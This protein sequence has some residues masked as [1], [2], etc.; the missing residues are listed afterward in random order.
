M[1]SLHLV[2][3]SWDDAARFVAMWHRHHGPPPGGKF[4][5]GAADD[6]GVLRGVHITGR[7]VAR[8]FDDGRTLEVTRLATDGTRNA[9]SLLYAAAWRA[10][11]ALGYTRLVTYTQE[12]ES[13][14]SLKAAGYQVVAQRAPRAGWT[15]PSRPRDDKG[16]DGIAR[17]LWEA[18]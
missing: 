5:A 7:P 16:A 9:G 15:C 18:M 4:W 6:M 13:G 11:K 8:S 10:A 1:T 17:T 14:A 12:G 2:P 3:V